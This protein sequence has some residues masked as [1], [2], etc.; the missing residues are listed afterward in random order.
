MIIGIL[1]R[2]TGYPNQLFFYIPAL[3]LVG[4]VSNSIHCFQSIKL[5]KTGLFKGLKVLTA[6]AT[7]IA[8]ITAPMIV[9]DS[10]PV[11]YGVFTICSLIIILNTISNLKLSE[12]LLTSDTLIIFSVLLSL[13]NAPLKPQAPDKF[14]DPEINSLA[15]SKNEGPTIYLDEAHNNF[16][17]LDG[18][19]WGFGKLMRNDGY[20]TDSFEEEFS[21]ESLENVEILVIS[22]AIHEKNVKDW[23]NP[24]FSAFAEAEI[25]AVK[26]WVSTGGSLML[27]ADHMP[28]GGAA[29]DLA[30]QFGV[31]FENGFVMDTI[32]N[33]DLF[34]KANSML[35]DT[36]LSKGID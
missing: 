18:L 11:I 30:A 22:N 13:L 25:A 20:K 27:I 33:F 2:L 17:R 16:H 34:T 35:E 6:I 14:Y 9:M 15:Y 5:S 29:K 7:L 1:I 24:T 12:S 8:L 31:E 10:N 4:L 26:D 36:E 21:K 28:F 23:S 3:L 19:Y 32:N